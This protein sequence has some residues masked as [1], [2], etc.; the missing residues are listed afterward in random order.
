V[1][2]F[3]DASKLEEGFI[4]R[5]EKP[6]SSIGTAAHPHFF[7]VTRIPLVVRPGDLIQ[8]VGVSSTIP[9]HALDPSR[10]IAMRW[11]AQRGGDPETGFTRRCYACVD[12]PHVLEVYQGKKFAL[13]VEAEFQRKFV[14]ADKLQTI[15]AAVN[16]LA[17]KKRLSQ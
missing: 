17:L 7:I 5:V 10:H 4:V 6:R 9:P 8:L 14:R 11:L 1:G 15:V 2:F 3:A 12:F 13:E 16:A